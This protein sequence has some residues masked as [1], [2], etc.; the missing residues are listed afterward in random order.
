VLDPFGTMYAHHW[1]P[2]ELTFRESAD[3]SQIVIDGRSSFYIGVVGRITLPDECPGEPSF[4]A[5]ETE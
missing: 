4:E 5:L 3:R 1:E 2:A